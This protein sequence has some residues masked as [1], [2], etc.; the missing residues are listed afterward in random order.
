[1]TTDTNPLQERIEHELE[2]MF[3]VPRSLRLPTDV[4]ERLS[5]L[6]AATGRSKSYYLRELVTGGIDDLEY[7]YGIAAR[8]EAIRDGSRETR[9]LDELMSEMGVSREAL[10]GLADAEHRATRAEAQAAIRGRAVAI[11]QRRAQEAEAERDW[12][13]RS[14]RHSKIERIKANA[15]ADRAEAEAR[16]QRHRADDMEDNA[17]RAQTNLRAAEERVDE[18]RQATL[19]ES[20]AQPRPLMHETPPAITLSRIR[21]LTCNAKRRNETIRPDQILAILE[22]RKA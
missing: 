2:A 22:R 21:Q 19:E 18:W 20:A 13:W 6:A 1:M 7:A 3:D 10:D 14:S 8:A 15:R 12:N 9:P 4:D 17:L 16:T 5:R 11:Y